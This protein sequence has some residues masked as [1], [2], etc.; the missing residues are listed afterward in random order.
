[1]KWA[2]A[3]TG[4]L[5]ASANAAFATGDVSCRS[6]DDSVS[7][8]LLVTRSTTLNVLRTVI[9]V[10]D[11]TWSSDPNVQAGTPILSGQAY[12]NDGMLLVDF[13]SEPAGAV[14]ARLKTFSL[15]EGGEY[16]SGGVFSLMGKGAWVVD[17]S[18]RG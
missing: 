16:A 15:E 8:S 1:M 10:G 7:V 6:A 17:C 18:E 11:E 14:S 5:L 9:S 2:L 4:F 3:V 13:I 12:E